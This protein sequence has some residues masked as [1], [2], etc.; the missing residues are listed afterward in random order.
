MYIYKI[1]LLKILHRIIQCATIFLKKETIF[2]ITGHLGSF[3]VL[4]FVNNIAINILT[5][6]AGETTIINL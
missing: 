2:P 4:A 1:N 3:Q 5:T 6:T